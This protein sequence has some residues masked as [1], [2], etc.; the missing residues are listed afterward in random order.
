MH[1]ADDVKNQARELVDA[2]PDDV[3]WDEFAR[4]VYERRMVER[5]RVDMAEGRFATSEQLREKFDVNQ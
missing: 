1:E 2:L 3:T 4:R 5:S